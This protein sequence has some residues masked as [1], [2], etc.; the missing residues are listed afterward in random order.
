MQAVCAVIREQCC[1]PIGALIQEWVH[2]PRCRASR[3]MSTI[4]GP[5]LRQQMSMHK[6]Q[7][8]CSREL[9]TGMLSGI[10][11]L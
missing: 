6:P 5:V 2:K 10:G 1:D 4:I 11:A 3:Q 9:P 8:L 7:W